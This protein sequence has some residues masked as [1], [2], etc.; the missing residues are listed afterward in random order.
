MECLTR[1]D[2]AQVQEMQTVKTTPSTPGKQLFQ[3][4]NVRFTDHS[5]E[6]DKC[7]NTSDQH[8]KGYQT[9]LKGQE[10]FLK[11]ATTT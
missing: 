1:G 3:K 4:E 7:I 8:R 6:T 9:A 10:V 2:T 5:T 11:K